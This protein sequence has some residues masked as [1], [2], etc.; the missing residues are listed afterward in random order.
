MILARP[1]TKVG[2]GESN[3]RIGARQ[4]IRGHFGYLVGKDWETLEPTLL[5]GCGW[6]GMNRRS[7]WTGLLDRGLQDGEDGRRKEC[8][9]RLH[10]EENII[11]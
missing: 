10:A 4:D 11:E 3:S 1:R 8:F 6:I 7:G 9:D 5:F 2:K